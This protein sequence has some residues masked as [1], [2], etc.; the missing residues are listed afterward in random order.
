MA[1]ALDGTAADIGVVADV[2]ALQIDLK[3]SAY[4]NSAHT[5]IQNLVGPRSLN[6]R[7]VYPNWLIF[8][9]QFLHSAFLEET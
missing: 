1:W 7:I 5:L 9:V 3:S 2:K 4:G 6:Y 8:A